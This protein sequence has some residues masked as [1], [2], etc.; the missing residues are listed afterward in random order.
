M[1]TSND[2]IN[3]MSV[4]AREVNKTTLELLKKHNVKSI[5]V[6]PYIEE[7]YISTFYFYDCDKDGNG[8]ALEV[9]TIEVNGDEINLEM[10]TNFGDYFGYYDLTDFTINEK[11]YLLGMLEG[12]FMAIEEHGLPLLEKGQ[13]FEE[14]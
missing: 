4:I 8:E 10:N 2:F 1:K 13:Y 12:I 7:N 14:D 5:N 3:E 11:I 9:S 6:T